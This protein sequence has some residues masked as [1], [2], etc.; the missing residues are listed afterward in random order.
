M[1]MKYYPEQQTIGSSAT[2]F[3]AIKGTNF[4]NQCVDSSWEVLISLTGVNIWF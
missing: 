3:F 4:Q 1:F 2:I